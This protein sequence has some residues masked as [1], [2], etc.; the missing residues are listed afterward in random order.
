VETTTFYGYG[1]SPL[2]RGGLRHLVGPLVPLGLIPARAGRTSTARPSSRRPTAHPRSRGADKT[3][4]ADS[5]ERAG[6]SPLAR[7]GPLQHGRPVR[8]IRLIPA[9]AGR[10]CRSSTKTCVTPA[11]PRSRGADSIFFSA[12]SVSAGSSPLARGGRVP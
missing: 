10:T 11:H 7:G 9:R 4:L 2:A 1:S 3:G 5:A 6:S 8:G 12:C